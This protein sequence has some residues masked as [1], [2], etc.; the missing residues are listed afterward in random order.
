MKNF[1]KLAITV[2]CILMTSVIGCNS[3]NDSTNASST[4]IK[5]VADGKLTWATSIPYNSF[6]FFEN[7]S[8]RGIDVEIADAIANKLGLMSQ[9][10]NFDFDSI[11]PSV[12]SG[13][14]DIGIA[15]LNITE[16][17]KKLVSFSTPYLDLRPVLLVLKDSPIKSIEN[18][19]GKKVGIQ[20]VS[21]ND[22]FVK[23]KLANAD[24]IFYNKE[25]KAI[26]DLKQQ[27]IDAIVFD[28][29]NAVKYSCEND[30]IMII[31]E[32]LAELFCAI[33]VSKDNPKLLSSINSIL[34]ELSESGKLDSIK[35][36]YFFEK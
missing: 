33:A 13:K 11:I 29:E 1:K 18:I 21:A 31:G 10:E 32:A 24:I 35:A 28:H 15:A 2:A 20:D 36:K 4:G 14:A 6:E 30:N 23:N 34:K 19:K 9:Y 27:K 7:D 16:S 26:E 22:D 25:S 17:R 12:A 5:N 3:S 8:L